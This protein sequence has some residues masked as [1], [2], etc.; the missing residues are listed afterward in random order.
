MRKWNQHSWVTYGRAI[1]WL[2][3][4]HL[5]S[6]AMRRGLVDPEGVLFPTIRLL[7]RRSPNC[8]GST[9]VNELQ[10]L[11]GHLKRAET[12]GEKPDP[13]AIESRLDKLMFLRLTPCCIFWEDPSRPSSSFWVDTSYIHSVL[14]FW[15]FPHIGVI[16]RTF[17]WR[18]PDH[19][20][21]R[22]LQLSHVSTSEGQ[23]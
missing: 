23:M 21:P 10:S 6:G 9:Y 20:K 14:F 17:G 12:I 19:P 1:V 16:E 5:H 13:S 22:E 18:S 4:K 7:G 11:Y 2:G 8:V 3:T 15:Q